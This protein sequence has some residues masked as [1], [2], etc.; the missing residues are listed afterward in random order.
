LSRI[1]FALAVTPMNGRK[2]ANVLDA[3]LKPSK[4]VTRAPTK[5]SK[6]KAEELEKAIDESSTPDCVK[7]GPSKHRPIEQVS[8]S[9]PEKISLPISEAVS[10]DNLGYIVRH[11][12]RKQ[13]TEEQIAKCNFMRKT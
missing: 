4:V 11:A 1:V 13:L 12:S 2:M 3:V 9:L 7:A 8:E 6:D 10:L 5:M